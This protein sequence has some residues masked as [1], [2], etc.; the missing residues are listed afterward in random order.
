MSGMEKQ[1]MNA[2]I[3][4]NICAENGVEIRQNEI[5]HKPDLID[6]YGILNDSETPMDTLVQYICDQYRDSYKYCNENQVYSM[7]CLI[8]NRNKYN[9][10]LQMVRQY[11]RE[12]PDD[13]RDHIADIS[14]NYFGIPDNDDLSHMIIKK[15]IFLAGM[16]M[17][18][19]DSLNP[20]GAET[21]AVF[22]GAQGCGKTL[23]VQCTA[24]EASL[25]RSIS[26]SA[27]SDEADNLSKAS[28]IFVGEIAEL[29]RSLNPHTSDFF[30]AFLT[31][32]KD[33]FRPKYGRTVCDYVRR[34]I[35]I[36]TCNTDRF[37]VD[38]TGN[39][40]YGVIPCR[41]M[42][43]ERLVK[44]KN[45]EDPVFIAAYAQAY[46]Y[47]QRN[48]M[49]SFRHTDQERE[50]IEIRNLQYMRWGECEDV[51]K[52]ALT[53]S[54]LSEFTIEQLKASS[55]A[56]ER[57]DNTQIGRALSHLAFP[58]TVKKVSHNGKKTAQRVYENKL[59][60][61]Q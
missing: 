56:L 21:M 9:P 16:A 36:A 42:N 60:R 43:I 40:R 57:F 24:L 46:K 11:I 26:F 8:A 48:G 7:L 20:Y 19:N 10:P 15:D 50:Q 59:L 6:N 32:G 58:Q 3:L 54:G 49:Q 29:E 1:A 47:L 35:Y 38:R 61:L 37:L 39:R 55:A 28:G 5:K 13:E 45:G 33:S 23:A 14:H 25:Y 18:Q 30:K 31:A 41:K 22:C 51:L 12:K 27:Y 52:S 17:V 4:Q 2:D 44:A 53:S 34:S